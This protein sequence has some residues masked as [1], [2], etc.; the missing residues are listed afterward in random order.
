MRSITPNLMHVLHAFDHLARLVA[1][2]AHVRRCRR[3]RHDRPFSVNCTLA[4]GC[5]KT[6]IPRNHTIGGT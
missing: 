2:A 1:H 4:H 6:F 3:H 5:V